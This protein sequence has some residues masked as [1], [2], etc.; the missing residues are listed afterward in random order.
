MPKYNN[1]LSATIQVKKAF[2][3]SKMELR[4]PLIFFLIM[5]NAEVFLTPKG[6]ICRGPI[7]KKAYFC[8][9]L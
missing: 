1:L 8:A 9:T 7:K 5:K 3:F 4:E 6:S 2:F